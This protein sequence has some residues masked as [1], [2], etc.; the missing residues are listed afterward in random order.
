MCHGEPR[1]AVSQDAAGDGASHRAPI[2]RL[3]LL[4][5]SANALLNHFIA[6]ALR[7]PLVVAPADATAIGNVVVQALALGHIASVEQA[8]EILRNSLKA[9]TLIPYATAWD[10]AYDR[11]TRLCSA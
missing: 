8:R 9:E 10:T 11:L 3:Y 6:N 5:G 4:G 1:F 7:R 2:A